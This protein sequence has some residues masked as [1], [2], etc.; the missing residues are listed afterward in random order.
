MRVICDL[1]A[2]GQIYYREIERSR[3]R[4]RDR[5]I[6]N[7][8]YREIERSRKIERDRERFWGT[9]MLLTLVFWNRWLFR[10]KIASNDCLF[11][12]RLR[13][14][15]VTVDAPP[16]ATRASHCA[17]LPP[18]RFLR[19]F[20]NLVLRSMP[21]REVIFT[22]A[23]AVYPVTWDMHIASTFTNSSPAAMSIATQDPF[24]R[25]SS[26]PR[27]GGR[28]AETSPCSFFRTE[29]RWSMTT[30]DTVGFHWSSKSS[31]PVRR[32]VEYKGA[33]PT[34]PVNCFEDNDRIISCSCEDDTSFFSGDDTLSACFGDDLK[35]PE[36]LESKVD[37]VG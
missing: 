20:N 30:V 1:R 34:S 33:P 36:V 22:D 35:A 6:E 19:P 23:G 27:F 26:V 9:I 4:S 12:R 2:Q 29:R 31:L 24:S 16:A 15:V 28:A 10:S 7:E 11:G 21:W 14:T 37:T 8:K 3:E 5:E 17:L 18:L 25:L 13:P 32:A